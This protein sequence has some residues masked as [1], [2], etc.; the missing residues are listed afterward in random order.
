[1]ATISLLPMNIFFP[2]FGSAPTIEYFEG[3][4][5]ILPNID[6]KN[7]N[8]QLSAKIKFNE[9]NALAISTASPVFTL[10][11]STNGVIQ[12][13]KRDEKRVV[14]NKKSGKILQKNDTG[15]RKKTDII[16]T[17]KMAYKANC[18]PCRI[19][20]CVIKTADCF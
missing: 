9:P 20:C 19:S 2:K 5:Y 14:K 10:Y 4:S 1:M 18:L 7:I 3:N 6:R 16:C 12:S 15:F 13:G 8:M 11:N 17:R